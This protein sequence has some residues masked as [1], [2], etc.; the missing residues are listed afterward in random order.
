MYSDVTLS[1]TAKRGV[2]NLHVLGVQLGVYDESDNFE[3]GAFK[4]L[5]NK[6]GVLSNVV[7]SI[8]VTDANSRFLYLYDYNLEQFKAAYNIN[9]LSNIVCILPIPC[10]ISE[11][12]ETNASGIVMPFMPGIRF[13]NGLTIGVGGGISDDPES[14][15]T[16]QDAQASFSFGYHEEP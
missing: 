12:L 13:N 4:V 15:G 3:V 5:S 16:I 1:P 2:K 11:Y 8:I 14:M 7:A 10:P 6:P 9:A